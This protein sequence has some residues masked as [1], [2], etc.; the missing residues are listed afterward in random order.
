MEKEYNMLDFFF[1]RSPVLPISNY[2]KWLEED[3]SD[4]DLLSFFNS[5]LD[6]QEI[7]QT[8][9]YD[10]FDSLKNGSRDIEKVK[11][12]LKNYIS[13][14]SARTTPYG[15]LSNISYGNFKK[16]KNN[17]SIAEIEKRARVDMEW[18]CPIFKMIEKDN[19]DKLTVKWNS[20]TLELGEKYI[21]EWNTCF[22]QN[23]NK[24]GDKSVI[25]CTNAVKLIKDNSLEFIRVE[26]LKNILKSTYPDVKQSVFSDFLK[27]LLEKEFLL[28][29][30]RSG[31]LVSDYLTELLATIAEFKYNQNDELINKLEK[32]AILI[33][34]YNETSI[35]TGI[36]IYDQIIKLMSSI[37]SSKNYIRIDSFKKNTM[38]LSTSD[39]AKLLD[40]V[41][42][43]KCNSDFYY[44]PNIEN[45]GGE[46]IERYS[47][48]EQLLADVIN[49]N[50]GIGLP[51]FDAQNILNNTDISF[52]K[53]LLYNI[54]CLSEMSEIDISDFN[55]LK[56][57]SINNNYIDDDRIE[58]S[59][60]VQEKN[61]KKTFSMSPMLGNNNLGSTIGRFLYQVEESDDSYFSS[62]ESNDLYDS[63]EITYY[64]QIDRICNIIN[65]K[66]NKKYVMEF[67][68]SDRNISNKRRLSISEIIINVTPKGIYFKHKETN[69]RLVFFATHSTRIDFAPPVI[70]FLLNSKYY[71]RKN[72]FTLLNKI[73]SSMQKLT[74]LPRITYK[75]IVLSEKKWVLPPHEF[76]NLNEDSFI[77]RFLDFSKEMNIEQFIF[78]QEFDNR[79]LINIMDYNTQKYIYK[80]YQ[81]NPNLQLVENILYNDVSDEEVFLSECV[82]YF[83]YSN[84]DF[85]DISN[86][87]SFEP[88]KKIK[89]RFLPFDNYVYLKIYTT[90]ILEDYLINKKLSP[91]LKKMLEDKNI[92]QFFFIRYE[93]PKPHIR[94]RFKYST[95]VNISANIVT[96]LTKYLEDNHITSTVII[97]TYIPEISRYGGEK[98]FS[99]MEYLFF[100]NSMVVLELN[101][102]RE[103]RNIDK[104][105]L[106]IIAISR[107]ILDT[108]MPDEEI[109][110]FIERLGNRKKHKKEFRAKRHE[111]MNLLINEKDISNLEINKIL[112]SQ[113][114]ILKDI[115]ISLE[116][117]EPY[118]T[119]DKTNV[120]MSIIHMFCNRYY[121]VD[122][123]KETFIQNMVS[124]T[125]HN[126]FS[127][128]NAKK[129]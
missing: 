96:D 66:S 86:R 18:I 34:Q 67:G 61:R 117:N 69:R 76:E 88:I 112:D 37:Y 25:N 121:G 39:K 115:W 36:E 56:M 95:K 62:L 84:K 13:R 89:E 6:V 108:E 119:N 1:T 120:L 68:C 46:Y 59:M 98:I 54:Q 80:S 64:P 78:I 21:N 40:L 114:K 129:K 72:T 14:M 16:E 101:K 94:L 125:I 71:Q 116:K 28:S 79:I 44:F 41:S 5:R 47:N 104:D 58:L 63:V 33:N 126:V 42:F 30:I 51:R 91:F 102:Y 57:K 7:I 100:L 31:P 82:F 105:S 53:E 3:N 2:L 4:E 26:D 23:E 10:L 97:D 17:K 99:K 65:T 106:A 52:E 107:L 74:I 50:T 110:S 27:D 32:V 111:Y 8:S 22:I 81:K 85:T 49:E 122:R 70:Q 124:K 29:N 9:S 45:W 128:E 20:Y 87:Y 83:N 48:T 118:V 43:L 75:D 38:Y 19:F 77:R 109:L 90:K 73:Q 127:Y 11:I 24:I 113:K 35:G 60:F 103:E 55:S 15:L 123:D 12:S 93:D 92:D